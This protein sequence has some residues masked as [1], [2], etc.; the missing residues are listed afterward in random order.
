MQ[1][2]LWAAILE[3]LK[4]EWLSSFSI[5]TLLKNIRI[6][7]K[8]SWGMQHWFW[9]LFSNLRTAAPIWHWERTKAKEDSHPMQNKSMESFQPRRKS[10]YHS[11]VSLSTFHQGY[12][13]GRPKNKK[14]LKMRLSITRQWCRV[15]SQVSKPQSQN[16]DHWASRGRKWISEEYQTAAQCRINARQR[17]RGRSSRVLQSTLMQGLKQCN[18]TADSW[19]TTAWEHRIATQEHRIAAGGW[20]PWGRESSQIATRAI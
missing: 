3:W 11:S 7:P 1:T 6:G 19:A 14:S 9:Y 2:N 16:Q 5:L 17:P 12:L 13:L 18:Q 10:A 20:G 4:F 8:N 15:T